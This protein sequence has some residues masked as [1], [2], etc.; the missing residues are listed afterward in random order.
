MSWLLRA[1]IVA[2]CLWAVPAQAALLD[3]LAFTSLGILNAIDSISVNTDT[4]ELTGGASFNGVLD[5]ISGSGIFAFDDIAGTNL[6]ISGTRTLGLLSKGNIAFTGTIDLLGSGGLEMVSGGTM[7]L[8]NLRTVGGGQTVLLAASQVNLK[9]PVDSGSRPL[10]ISTVEPITLSGEIGRGNVSLSAES[11]LT[12]TTGTG[13]TGR[14]VTL[15]SGVITLTGG[16]SSGQI[17]I[18]N[19][20]EIIGSPGVTIVAP[21]PLPASVLLFATGLVSIAAVGRLKKI[22][23]QALAR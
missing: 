2:F 19:A 13:I 1:W 23:Q 22:A 5:P 12:V 7:T 10:G 17:T 9:G 18:S 20:G 15:G 3:P 21:V 6:S 16:T 8:A 14:T 4:L 11:G